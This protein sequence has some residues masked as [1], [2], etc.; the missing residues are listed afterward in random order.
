MVKAV[1]GMGMVRERIN[2]WVRTALSG[3]RV[4]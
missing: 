2:I 3:V 4:S 1:G